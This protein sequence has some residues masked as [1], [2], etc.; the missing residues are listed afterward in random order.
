MNER[1][2]FLAAIEIDDPTE[3]AAYLDQTCADNTELRAQVDELLRTV[4][5]SHSIQVE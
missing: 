3:R 5:C 1:D 4:Q 2:I